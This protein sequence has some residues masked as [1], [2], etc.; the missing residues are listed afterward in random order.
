MSGDRDRRGRLLECPHRDAD[1]GAGGAGGTASGGRGGTNAAGTN[2]AAGTTGVAGTSGVAGTTG[3]AGTS[4][5]DRR[6]LERAA[7]REPEASPE[8]AGSPERAGLPGQRAS[9]GRVAGAEPRRA[10]TGGGA[11]TGAG[12]LGGG[13]AG[14]TGAPGGTGGGA[15]GGRGGTTGVAGAGGTGGGAGGIAGGG[16]TAAGGRGGGGPGGASGAPVTP[17]VA[18]QIVI[19]ELMHDTDVVG[20]DFGEW[21]EIY[22]PHPTNSY[23]MFGCQLRDL[24]NS[25]T[26][27]GHLIV[28]PGAFRT[29]AISATMVGFVPDYTYTTVKFDN[30]AADE[31]NIFCSGTLI[32]RF[33]Y[34]DTL[35]RTSGRTFGVDPDHYN[36]A[37]NDNPAN[38]CQ[39]ISVYVMATNSGGDIIR[40][41][42]TPGAPNPQCP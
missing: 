18:G 30:D 22:N 1:A 27:G 37:D 32:D 15:A 2:G 8:P 42:G 21:I 5:G 29:L 25:H 16:G 28:P 6:R 10:A 11:G 4:G 13:G 26:I 36:A 35:A 20:D 38:Y 9:P 39:A 41:Y 24:V 7:A 17:S 31:A 3:V 23:D 40:D 33:G 34:S 12:G 14:G 19:T